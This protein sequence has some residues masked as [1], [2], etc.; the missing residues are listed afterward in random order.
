MTASN[1]TQVLAVR[2]SVLG[3]T[4]TTPRM[5]TMRITGESLDFAPEYVDS[6]ELRADRMLGDPI[7]VGQSSGGGI[8]FELSY[9]DNESPLSELLRSAFFSTWVNTPERFN[10]GVADAVVTDVATTN[11]EVTHTTGAAFVAGHLVR[12]TG[13]GVAGNN[14]VF[15]CTTG[16]AT[17][18]RYVGSGVTNEAAPPAAARM[19]VVG[20][21]GASGDISATASGLASSALDFTTLGL[22]VGQWIKIGGT[23]TGDKFATAAL[24]DWARIAAIAAS[25]IT[26]DNRPSGWTTDAGAGKTL[27]VWF[28]DQIKN[29]TT[30][31]SL[32]IER[33]FLGQDTPTYIVN[34]GMVVNTMELSI[35]AKAR[36]GGSFGFMGMGGGAGTSALDASPDAATTGLILAGSANVGRLGID[37]SGVTGPNWARSIR[38]G[39]NNNLRAIEAL[40]QTAPVGINEGEFGVTIDVETYFGSLGELTKFYNSTATAINSRV[41]RDGQ[42]LIWQVPRAQYRGGGN[43]QAS[44]KNADVMAAFQ[45]QASIDT[46]TNAHLI[47]DRL[48]YYEA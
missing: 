21:Q 6:D 26:L 14:G 17:T 23:A 41:Q 16:G 46:L 20:F 27:K 12:F 44:G 13:F 34:T 45:A 47:L 48:P 15:K 43:P 29:G 11:T 40:D 8:N 10:D 5:R 7:K 42:A 19:K 36:I 1:R 4:P 2:E 9:P 37:G 32:T 25:A 22:A 30:K 28:G 35:A 3:T 33:G 38:L 31:T 18:S 39:V 24:N